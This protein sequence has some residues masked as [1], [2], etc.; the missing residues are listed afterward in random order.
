MQRPG[1]KFPVADHEQDNDDKP[2]DRPGPDNGMWRRLAEKGHAE[3]V[4]ALGKRAGKAS[5]WRLR[6]MR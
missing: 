4:G 5:R 3:C 2:A 1:L 6:R